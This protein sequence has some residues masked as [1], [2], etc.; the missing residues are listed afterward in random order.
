MAAREPTSGRSFIKLR[1]HVGF[2]SWFLWT[3]YG[4]RGLEAA[5]GARMTEF[6]VPVGTPPPQADFGLHGPAAMVIGVG[7]VCYVPSLLC[8]GW[9]YVWCSPL[10]VVRLTRPV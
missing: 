10:M 5:I 2:L 3:S 1:R 9:C 6:E 4:A 8:V 7:V